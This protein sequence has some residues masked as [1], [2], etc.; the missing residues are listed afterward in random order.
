MYLIGGSNK[1]VEIPDDWYSDPNKIEDPTN[2]FIEIKGDKYFLGTPIPTDSDFD[3]Y[4]K[5]I[6]AKRK[7]EVL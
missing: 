5:W 1:R 2:Y 7:L 6:N 3:L 4:D